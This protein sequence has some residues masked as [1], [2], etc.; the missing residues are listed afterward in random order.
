[1]FEFAPV[2][3][4]WAVSPSHSWSSEVPD[5]SLHPSSILLSLKG[6]V[7]ILVVRNECHDAKGSFSLSVAVSV[8]LFF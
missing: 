2:A 1:M 3:S 4:W 7:A 6:S 8:A 5:A